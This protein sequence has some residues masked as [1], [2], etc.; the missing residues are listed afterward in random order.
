[1]RKHP[2]EPSHTE[3]EWAPVEDDSGLVFEDGAA[4]IH[5]QC[6]WVEVTGSQTHDER[7]E[8]YYEYGAECDETRTLRLELN[9]IRWVN[10]YGSSEAE[11]GTRK[12][13]KYEIHDIEEALE[14]GW[15]RGAVDDVEFRD[16]IDSVEIDPDGDDVEEVRAY[17]GNMEVIYR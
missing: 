2:P 5:Q 8:T 9:Q 3:H 6:E 17:I 10:V 1:M 11:E 13:T 15:V 7:D 16:K 14:N 12:V 4:I